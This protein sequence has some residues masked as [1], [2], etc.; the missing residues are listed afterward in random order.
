MTTRA[1]SICGVILIFLVTGCANSAGSYHLLGSHTS[2]SD[3][4]H[5]VELHLEAHSEDGVHMTAVDRE[6]LLNKILRRVQG[7][8]KEASLGSRFC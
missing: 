7:R 3:L 6:R 5:F 2:Q 4:S 1:L 8:Y